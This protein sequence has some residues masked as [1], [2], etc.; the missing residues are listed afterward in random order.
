MVLATSAPPGLLSTQAD[1]G[2]G[3]MLRGRARERRQK[4]ICRSIKRFNLET[5]DTEDTHPTITRQ[6]VR[7]GLQTVSFEAPSH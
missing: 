7:Q 5:R 6:T 3:E 1:G 4:H 2:W